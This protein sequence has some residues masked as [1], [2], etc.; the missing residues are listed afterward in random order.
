MNSR[1][2]YQSA[3]NFPSNSLARREFNRIWMAVSSLTATIHDPTR[4]VILNR[5]NKHIRKIRNLDP[6]RFPTGTLREVLLPPGQRN[7]RIITV[8]K[9][10]LGITSSWES[11]EQGCSAITK[12][13][14]DILDHGP[15]CVN[16]PSPNDL[17]PFRTSTGSAGE[18]QCA[19]LAFLPTANA[20]RE[21]TRCRP[22]GS[23]SNSPHSW[24]RHN[25]TVGLRV[26]ARP[27]NPSI[28]ERGCRDAS[29]PYRED[30]A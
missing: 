1:C 28:L 27:K 11:S 25:N 6:E 12:V 15:I 18:E 13:H 21:A 22:T 26:T 2:S 5:D 4:I 8:P 9:R 3:L 24:T 19:S 10:R 29:P 20:R 7:L 23:W 14:P 30:W 16:C 17:V